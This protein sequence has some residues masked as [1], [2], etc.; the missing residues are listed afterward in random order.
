MPRIAGS[1]VVVFESG[2][3]TK[4]PIKISSR[5]VDEYFRRGFRF[6]TESPKESWNPLDIVAALLPRRAI[7]QATVRQRQANEKAE[8]QRVAQ[9]AAVEKLVEDPQCVWFRETNKKFMVAERRPC[10]G[11]APP[12]AAPSGGVM[13][14]ATL[15]ALGWMR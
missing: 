9:E 7:R 13:Q 3:W 15:M 11:C 2:R 10:G 1:W 6:S 14:W 4:G 8:R 5:A 12:E